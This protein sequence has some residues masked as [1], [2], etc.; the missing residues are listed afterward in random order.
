MSLKLL[1]SGGLVLGMGLAAV[2]APA[3]EASHLSDPTRCTCSASLS[4]DRS[5]FLWSSEGLVF[6]PRVNFSIRARGGSEAPPLNV[7]VNY[8]GG[9]SYS[10]ED[11]SVPDG[12]SFGGQKQVISGFPCN[13]TYRSSGV[14]LTRVTLSGLLRSLLGE[15]QELNGLVGMKA[16]IQGCGFDEE[17]RQASFRLREFGNLRIG[18]WRSVR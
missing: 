1:A 17:N 9:T 12:A 7:A 10:S 18:G 2:V 8:E 13:G 5:S 16:N 6:I 15:G 11:V 3:A 14:E 4:F